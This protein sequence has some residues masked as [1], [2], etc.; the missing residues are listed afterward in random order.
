MGKSFKLS[1]LIWI[2]L[3]AFHAPK[4]KYR[5]TLPMYGR[6]EGNNGCFLMKLNGTKVKI[7]SGEG[8]GWEHVSVSRVDK[9]MPNWNLMCAVKELFWDDE[10]CVVQYHPPKSEYVSYHPTCLHLWRPINEKMPAPPSYMVG[11]SNA[12]AHV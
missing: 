12:R 4:D 11:P 3:M 9:K 7:M 1:R 2:N 10:D 8:L 6:G 5:V